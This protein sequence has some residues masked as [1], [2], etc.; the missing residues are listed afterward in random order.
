MKSGIAG[1]ICIVKERGSILGRITGYPGFY[2]WISW[3]TLEDFIAKSV[4][5]IT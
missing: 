5:K 1:A 4:E 3:V 2:Q